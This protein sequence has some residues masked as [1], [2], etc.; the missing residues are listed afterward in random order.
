MW[1]R[2]TV[3]YSIT[4][5]VYERWPLSRSGSGVN[6]SLPTLESVQF[7]IILIQTSSQIG[8]HGSDWM[9]YF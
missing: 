2:D 5:F 9:G 8:W 3:I 4:R 1:G 6:E 7:R